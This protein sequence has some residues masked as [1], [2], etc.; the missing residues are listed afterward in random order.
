[1]SNLNQLT[2]DEI[3]GNNGSLQ[4]TLPSTLQYLSI[5]NTNLQNLNEKK[6]FSNFKNIQ[7]LDLENTNISLLE[8]QIFSS[9][10][11]LESLNLKRNNLETLNLDLF[12]KLKK[13]EVLSLNSNKFKTIP[14]GITEKIPTLET[15]SMKNNDIKIIDGNVFHKIIEKKIPAPITSSF[16]MAHGDFFTYFGLITEQVKS[17]SSI[18]Y[19]YLSGNKIFNIEDDA[20]SGLQLILL[21]LSSNT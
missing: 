13:L 20:F 1:M 9:L 4:F 18:K 19:I 15:L 17:P 5:Y 16:M 8:P 2:L 21:D 11:E 14:N 6:F 3:T 7:S 12:S 10:T